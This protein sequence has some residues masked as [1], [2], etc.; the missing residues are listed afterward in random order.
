[1]AEEIQQQVQQQQAAW[2]EILE[3]MRALTA[4]VRQVKADVETMKAPRG[5]QGS[6]TPADEE[7]EE[8]KKRKARQEKSKERKSRLTMGLKE[9]KEL[10]GEQTEDQGERPTV[11]A[12]NLVTP[13]FHGRRGED[14]EL[15]LAKLD[16]LG[17]QQGWDEIQWIETLKCGL[18]DKA[19]YFA[20]IIKYSEKG[21]I[22][23][24]WVREKFLTF[25]G[26]DDRAS[27]AASL[28]LEIRQGEKET[29]NEYTVRFESILR[30]LEEPL[31]DYFAV[32]VYL[33]GV[34]PYISKS[35]KSKTFG[36]WEAAFKAAR[37]IERKETGD[38]MTWS[39]KI[40][41]MKGEDPKKKK[42]KEKGKYSKKPKEQWKRRE[43]Q[44][45]D[46][47]QQNPAAEPKPFKGKCNKCGKVGHK[48]RF[49]TSAD[50]QAK[51]AATQSQDQS[52]KPNQN[53][54]LTATETAVCF[55]PCVVG[56]KT[57][58]A[59]IDTGASVSWVKSSLVTK[60]E[61]TEPRSLKLADGRFI[62]V[63]KKTKINFALGN[64]A[65]T[66]EFWIVSENT[67]K[68]F[69]VILGTDFLF[70]NLPFQVTLKDDKPVVTLNGEELQTIEIDKDCKL[71]AGMT[72][73]HEVSTEEIWKKI[74][75]PDSRLNEEQK[76]QMFGLFL[77]FRD[78]LCNDL[79]KGGQAKLEP[80]KIVLKNPDQKP[81]A[82]RPLRTSPRETELVDEAI[83]K[84]LKQ[85]IIRPSKSP[86]ASPMLLVRKEDNTSRSVIDY[87]DLNS[88]TKPEA[89]PLPM[90]EDIFAS[91]HGSKFWIKFDLASGYWQ[92]PLDEESIPLAAFVTQKGKWE[93]LVMP[94]G[95]K[96]AVA[97]FQRAMIDMYGDFIGLWLWIHVDDNLLYA[98]LFENELAHARRWL[99]ILREYNL[100]L[101]WKKSLICPKKGKFI[102]GEFDEFGLYPEEEK[103]RVV[104]EM[105]EPKNV[106]EVRAFLG[107]VGYYR[108]FIEK[109]AEKAYP[110]TKL[111]K[112]D[113]PWQW[114]DEEREAWRV[115]RDALCARPVLAYP[116]FDKL[117][118][119]FTDA[120]DIAIAA[121]LEQEDDKGILHVILYA[122]K[123]LNGSEI[124]WSV[125]DKECYAVVFFLKKLRHYVDG[126]LDEVITDHQAL[127]TLF[128]RKDP[129]GRLA[130][131]IEEL[132]S[133]FPIRIRHRPGRIHNNVDPL[134]REPFIRST[135][136]G[137]N[138][139]KVDTE[140]VTTAKPDASESMF[141]SAVTEVLETELLPLD[142][143]TELKQ[144]EQF[145][146]IWDELEKKKLVLARR[147]GKM[148]GELFVI[149]GER[150]LR[151]WSIRRGK[152]KGELRFLYVV[153]RS[154][155]EK[156]LE[157]YHESLM[158]AHLG[159]KK[160]YEKLL[161]RYWWP[162][163]AQD[164]IEWCKTCELC[165]AFGPTGKH[166]TGPLKPIEVVRRRQ[167]LGVD[168]TGPLPE[169]KRGNR[170]I[171]MCMYHFERWPEAVPLR[172]SRALTVAQNLVE[173]VLS[174]WGYPELMLSD[175]GAEFIASVTKEVCNL[176][177]IQQLFSSSYHPETNG[178]VEDENKIVKQVIEKYV[179]LTQTDWD[180]WLQPLMFSL[181]TSI[182]DSVGMSPFEVMFGIKP[183]F[184]GEI[185]VPTKTHFAK[186]LKEKMKQID[187]LVK[188]NL[189]TSQSK[190]KERIDE[191]NR[192][193]LISYKVGD[194]VWILE[195]RK[196]EKGTTKK[197]RPKW[198]GPY[199]VME[200]L[201]PQV[202]LV[203][204]TGDE[205]S[206]AMKVNIK[207][208]KPYSRWKGKERNASR[209]YYE[210]EAVRKHRKKNGMNEYLVRWKGRTKSSD[211]W[212]KE[213]DL[214]A[215]E[216][217]NAYWR[218]VKL[219]EGKKEKKETGGKENKKRDVSLEAGEYGKESVERE[220]SWWSREGKEWAK[221]LE[222]AEGRKR[223]R[224]KG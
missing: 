101:K 181:R 98:L 39:K 57:V 92:I 139:V 86:W 94:M 88:V 80:H 49:C 174:R 100:F 104:R 87:R 46:R 106:K 146:L 150:L 170:Y 56:N 62:S 213:S 32:E 194:E 61:E 16:I 215:D 178:L 44:N 132:M 111:T 158:G 118:K 205:S 25:Y 2:Q 76:K 164:V 154:V 108:R 127:V 191:K 81:I 147:R 206:K 128:D 189:M 35:L 224:K 85:G 4:E 201:S 75:Y 202:I 93:P 60:A 112:K 70:K 182:Q 54:A 218:R 68:T 7:E 179:D 186:D 66:H 30:Q 121:T 168:L 120:S 113:Q 136:S 195:E 200:V 185:D 37:E 52:K 157:R 78:R 197:L 110:L 124:R 192:E 167:L 180:I 183:R 119:L 14:A 214:D 160:V 216:L 36:T 63:D 155:R 42:G 17:E 123:Q 153:P 145:S 55:T 45:P 187:D 114:T 149:E 175:N 73:I 151:T 18:R 196:P 109:F 41:E 198:R 58:P 12:A 48:A 143:L 21:K 28:L 159:W 96:N 24:K 107:F 33:H 144:D 122:S 74:D 23:V 69:P 211:S 204:L 38:K 142:T 29:V 115:L 13:E 3:Q 190:R 89:Y 129:R 220:R 105:N 26:R 5:D 176:L 162:G 140:I 47:E 40:A 152:E 84:M 102:G 148:N 99:E 130:R 72:E 165:Q 210:I 71:A 6:A 209:D 173:Q 184:P 90:S 11:W 126:R 207:R 116:D 125:T 221:R 135:L 193:K 10:G 171:L 156:I 15:F 131:W 137:E 27:D 91:L 141:V 222:E 172:D 20:D 1:M 67:G 223:R 83:K 19:L 169:T 59:L 166:K 22:N 50:N 208:T 95:L 8:V 51:P 9:R 134:T 64:K 82:K 177:G 138:E 79:T 77:E 217:L 219:L 133:W 97:S 103:I 43:Q 188:E 203:K 161:R 163:M 65:Y 199:T 212:V 31:P 117:F 53:A 34:L